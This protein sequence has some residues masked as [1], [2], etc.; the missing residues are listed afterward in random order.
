MLSPYL[1]ANSPKPKLTAALRVRTRVRVEFTT[2]P[3][4]QT[5]QA[6]TASNRT[7]IHAVHAH[8][9]QPISLSLTAVA[10]CPPVAHALRDKGDCTAHTEA[11]SK[12][13]DVG[14]AS[15]RRGEKSSIHHG[16]T[17]PLKSSTAAPTCQ[18]QFV[19]CSV[20]AAKG[21]DVVTCNFRV[22]AST[23]EVQ[24][25][26]LAATSS[27]SPPTATYK[28]IPGRSQAG[29][30]TAAAVSEF[31]SVLFKPVLKATLKGKYTY[32]QVL[33]NVQSAPRCPQ[34]L[35]STQ[36]ANI[37]SQQYC[38]GAPDL[39]SMV[40]QGRGLARGNVPP[41]GTDETEW[42]EVKLHVNDSAS[43]SARALNETDE[44]VK[45]LLQ[46]GDGV[47][48]TFEV[49]EEVV[50][51]LQEVSMQHN[52]IAAEALQEQ[53]LPLDGVPQIFGCTEVQVLP[54]QPPASS[55]LLLG[56]T[57]CLGA[58]HFETSCAVSNS[59]VIYCDI[60]L[61]LMTKNSCLKLPK[62][63]L[64]ACCK[65][66]LFHH[67]VSLLLCSTFQCCSELLGTQA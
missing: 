41:Q 24:T 48:V 27:K 15:H 42:L 23:G 66:E 11:A 12:R 30:A 56:A 57:S 4:T 34:Q 62:A 58:D 38:S 60:P 35:M 49:V 63:V 50:L 29:S 5:F 53:Q 28:S 8:N 45:S 17:K 18:S 10:H 3:S 16:G 26:A 25:K 21:A 43:A 19:S 6:T 20:A 64:L 44:R 51:D 1:Q 33:L 7:P 40:A 14:G 37:L 46:H 52:Q 59:G 36:P 47:V 39:P 67:S 31:V 54:V 9:Q 32:V 65:E 55:D 61:T 13:V 2:Q 22:Q